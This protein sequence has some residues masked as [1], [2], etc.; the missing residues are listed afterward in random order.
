LRVERGGAREVL[1]G[2]GVGAAAAQ[3]KGFHAVG[4]QTGSDLRF[5]RAE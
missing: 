2:V 1:A 3:G 4:R 5:P